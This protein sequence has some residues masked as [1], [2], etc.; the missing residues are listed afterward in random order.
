MKKTL[1]LKENGQLK[2]KKNNRFIGPV[3]DLE[4]HVHSNW[5]QNIF[6]S[7]YLKTDGDVVSDPAITKRE[8]DLCVELLGLSPNDQIL[9]ICCGQGRHVIELSERGFHVTGLDRSRYLIKKAKENARKL[10][11]SVKFREGDARKLPF[12]ADSFDAITLMGNS[13][14]YFESIQDDIQVLKEA[15]RVLKPQGKIMLEL[16]DGKYLRESFQARSWEWMDKKHF[17]CRERSLSAD[18]QRLI[19]REVITHVAKGVIADQ[20]YGERLYSQDELIQLLDK[21]GFRNLSYHGEIQPE[22]SRNQDLG[23]MERCIIVTGQAYKEWSPVKKKPKEELKEVVVL[24]GDPSQTDP[25]KPL[26]VFDED[27]IYT[28]DQMKSALNSLSG[29]KFQYLT[30][31]KTLYHELS[32]LSGKIQFAFNLCDEGFNNDPLKELHVPAL[33][34]VLGIAY[35]GAATQCLAY[36]YDKSLVRGIAQEM[37]IPVP[38]AFFIGAEDTTFELPFGFPVIVKP[39]FGDSSFGITQS[40]VAYDLERL[41]SAIAEIRDKLGYEKPVLV[42]EFLGGADISV[43]II[44]NSPASYSILPIIEEDYSGLPP[45]LPRICGYEAKWLPDS[46]YGV[47]TSVAANLPDDTRNFVEDCCVKLFERLECRD[48]SRFDW[49]LTESGEPRLL[50]VNPNPGW[51]W[52]GHL[53]KMCKIA[54]IS[55]PEMLE[56]ILKATEMR[57]ELQTIQRNSLQSVSVGG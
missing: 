36:C 9:D 44:G 24:L 39:N 14:G 40:S 38:R 50:E 32:K 17:V 8:A 43:G 11:L 16:A 31:H 5:W 12:K 25:L 3:T 28:I 56:K 33:L 45:E 4:R 6:N 10:G 46:A 21:A 20:F 29:Y 34:D 57:L 42:E 35:T 7:M 13:F 55:Y 18:G 23:M 49:R 26:S 22:S 19:S 27:D 41:V 51:C 52:D 53:A 2:M 48:Y 1:S 47:I 15:L 30:N 54:N 37:G